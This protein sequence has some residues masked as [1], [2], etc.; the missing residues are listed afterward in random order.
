MFVSLEFSNNTLLSISTPMI[1]FHPS[2]D[3]F[4]QSGCFL[5]EVID[6]LSHRAH[7]VKL[8]SHTKGSPEVGQASD[9]VDTLVQQFH[10]GH[11]LSSCIKKFPTILPLCF[12]LALVRSMSILVTSKEHEVITI[13]MLWSIIPKRMNVGIQYPLFLPT[14]KYYIPMGGGRPQKIL[15]F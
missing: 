3:T 9:L 10:K 8:F 14:V 1:S 11:V 4:Y 7:T 2:V 5:L 6:I 12:S 15:H 13:D